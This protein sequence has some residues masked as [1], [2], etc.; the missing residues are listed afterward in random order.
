MQA[1]LS[2]SHPHTL[3]EALL[4]TVHKRQTG[5]GGRKVTGVR[6]TGGRVTGVQHKLAVLAEEKPKE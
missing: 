3:E 1:S 4:V 5:Q 2:P 6:V